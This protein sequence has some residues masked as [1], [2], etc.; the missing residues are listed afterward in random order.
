MATRSDGGPVSQCLV[1]W[2]TGVRR[3]PILYEAKSCLV[4]ASWMTVRPEPQK[5]SSGDGIP[6]D[7]QEINPAVRCGFPTRYRDHAKPVR[8]EDE[9]VLI[10]EHFFTL[11]GRIGS[12]ALEN[13]PSSVYGVAVG[14]RKLTGADHLI[15]AMKRAETRALA[16]C[17]VGHADIPTF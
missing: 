6:E 10:H 9:V 5:T 1:V 17:W 15:G 11:E 14:A 2:L 12:V 16:R 4:S 13:K 8:C 7:H 3:L